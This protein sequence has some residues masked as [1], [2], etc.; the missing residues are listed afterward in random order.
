MLQLINRIFQILITQNIIKIKKLKIFKKTPM[1]NFWY[2][3]IFDAIEKLKKIPTT[4]SS[5]RRQWRNL[6]HHRWVT[7][8]I[9]DTESTSSSARWPPLWTWRHFSNGRKPRSVK[10]TDAHATMLNDSII[11]DASVQDLYF[12]SQRN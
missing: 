9:D 11:C 7:K 6:H 2:Y 8:P 5:V 4:K 1:T 10:F 3:R 12:F